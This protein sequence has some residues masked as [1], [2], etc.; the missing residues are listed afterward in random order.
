MQKEEELARLHEENN[1]LRQYLNSALVKCLEEK[2]KV[3]NYPLLLEQ[4]FEKGDHLGKTLSLNVIGRVP[5]HM[6]LNALI[7]WMNFSK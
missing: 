1:H 7:G 5:N 3:R 4:R 6:P 2:T